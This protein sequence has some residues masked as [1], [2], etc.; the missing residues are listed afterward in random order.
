MG[1]L[2]SPFGL[3]P[4][5]K[6]DVAVRL[7]ENCTYNDL[8]EC[9]LSII[10]WNIAQYCCQ[11]FRLCDVKYTYCR[12]FRNRSMNTE[13]VNSFSI[14]LSISKS[15]AADPELTVIRFSRSLTIVTS[16]TRPCSNFTRPR[17]N[18]IIYYT[19]ICNKYILLL[20]CHCVRYKNVIGWRLRETWGKP[21]WRSIYR[22]W[23]T[24]VS[25]EF[26]FWPFKISRIR[27]E[28]NVD[29]TFWAARR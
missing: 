15:A 28:L 17:Y 29:Q 23:A 26:R 2:N 10:D 25:A 12:N 18:E 11:F 22:H 14:Y 6:I 4:F 21:R 19:N 9:Y 24:I 3:Y 20:G 1:S 5:I 8:S 27:Y 13:V 7:A 16:R